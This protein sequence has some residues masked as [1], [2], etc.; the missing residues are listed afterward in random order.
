MKAAVKHSKRAGR[1]MAVAGLVAMSATSC[2]AVTPTMQPVPDAMARQSPAT[3]M[4]GQI[5]DGENPSWMRL[6]RDRDPAAGY[7]YVGQFWAKAV[8]A[9]RTN[10][11]HNDG[12]VCEIPI[13][14]YALGISTDRLGRIYV[15]GDFKNVHGQQI[16]GVGVFG[17][18]CGA[19]ESTFD[20]PYGN[21]ED[22][23]VDGNTLY[24]S[25]LNDVAVPGS[26]AVYDLKG[27]SE[28]VSQLT[29]PNAFTGFGAAVDSHHNLFWANADVW[30]GGGQVI[31][32]RKG[33]MPG[34]VLNATKIGTDEPGGVILD[35]SNNLLLIDQNTGV[36]N[37]YAAPYK[38]QPFSTIRMK[39]SAWYCAM[40]LTQTRLYC[41]DDTYASVDTYTYP[42]GKYLFSYNNGIEG[43][44]GPV[45][46]TIQP[47]T[48]GNASK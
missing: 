25:T 1:A 47:P 17:P 41:L 36:V 43:K 4:A 18:H 30:T 44:D 24:V 42:G 28:P 7:T 6:M 45:G 48:H 22:P 11:R 38:A 21:P 31:E 9:Y 14:N 5:Y 19:P 12:P 3:T 16:S 40:G 37:I 29:D 26:V 8:L 34:V 39:G 27:G 15:T 32:F 33:K 20:D 2:S 13:E 23:V 10:D 46:I 35:K